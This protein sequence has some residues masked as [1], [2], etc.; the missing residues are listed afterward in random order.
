MRIK[1]F[2]EK[3]YALWLSASDTYQWANR[4]GARWPCSAASGNRL[5]LRVDENGLCEL[6]V[7]GRDDADIGS[8]ELSAI[9]AD[10]LPRDLRHLWPVWQH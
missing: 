8:D 2:G 7:N 9:V 4:S 1:R 5:A 6:L 3:E 10:H